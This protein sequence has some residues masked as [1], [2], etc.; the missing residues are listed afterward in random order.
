MRAFVS[1]NS[2]RFADFVQ[3]WN[4]HK[5]Y[6][7][8]RVGV[9]GNVKT[10]MT[11]MMLRLGAHWFLTEVEFYTKLA[12]LYFMYAVYFAQ[13]C[14]PKC[15]IRVTSDQWKMID[16]MH[17]E[18][19]AAT[20]WDAVYVLCQLRAASA[21]TICYSPRLLSL[22]PAIKGGP[23]SEMVGIVQDSHRAV[24][25]I[26]R[27]TPTNLLM[28]YY[29]RK[30]ELELCL[31]PQLLSRPTLIQDIEKVLEDMG[32]VSSSSSSLQGSVQSGQRCT[33]E[34]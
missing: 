10:E 33:P 11:D 22:G 2:L 19:I 1:K 15:Q 34:K 28:E 18:M 27:S 21:F 8:Y 23:T 24:C 12:G 7:V 31:P 9:E 14:S 4:E 17:Q 20:H 30:Q 13:P 16:P 3:V 29:Q 6:Y 26:L 5:F 25:D 32:G